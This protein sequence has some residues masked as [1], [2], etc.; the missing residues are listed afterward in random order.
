M[1]LE[2]IHK[3]KRKKYMKLE[4]SELE[5]TSDKKKNWKLLCPLTQEHD[6]NNDFSKRISEIE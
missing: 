6:L 3:L 2:L 4:E 1:S 5:V